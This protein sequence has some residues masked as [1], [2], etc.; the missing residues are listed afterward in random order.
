MTN[1]A[2][3]LLFAIAFVGGFLAGVMYQSAKGTAAKVSPSAVTT[4]LT[5]PAIHSEIPVGFYRITGS[6]RRGTNMAQFFLENTDGE[7]GAYEVSADFVTEGESLTQGYFDTLEVVSSGAWK[8][9]VYHKRIY[10]N[11]Y[12]QYPSPDNSSIESPE[13][14]SSK[15]SKKSSKGTSMNT[16]AKYGEYYY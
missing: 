8:K 6:G 4:V 14:P 11:L 13:K 1:S 2:K 10:P 15:N 3:L 12:A 9:A 7:V 16:S 5:A